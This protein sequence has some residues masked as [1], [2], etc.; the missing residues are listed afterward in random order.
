MLCTAPPHVIPQSAT[1]ATLDAVIPTGWM[2]DGW[3][4]GRERDE[5]N[6]WKKKKRHLFLSF[7]N[8]LNVTAPSASMPPVP[9]PLKYIKGRVER[10]WEDGERGDFGRAGGEEEV[11]RR[12]QTGR[13]EPV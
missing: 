13:T 5:F 1:A 2:I 6:H 3:M 7:T 9:Q 11:C 10:R 8:W 12:R 4:E